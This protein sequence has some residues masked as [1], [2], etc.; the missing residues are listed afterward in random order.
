MRLEILADLGFPLRPTQR[1]DHLTRAEQQMVEIAKAFRSEL[2]VLILDEPTASLTE[3]E[4]E[5]L[6]GA[7]RP[8]EGPMAWASSTSPIA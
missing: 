3:R 7:H 4:T 8:G 2:S 1:V 6:F 5:Q